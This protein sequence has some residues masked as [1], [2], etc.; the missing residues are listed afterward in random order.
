MR[1]LARVVSSIFL[2]KSLIWNEIT[3]PVSNLLNYAELIE[4]ELRKNISKKINKHF[5]S[6]QFIAVYCEVLK[7]T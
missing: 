6:I 7:T 5:F 3:F 4:N 1:Y 2:P